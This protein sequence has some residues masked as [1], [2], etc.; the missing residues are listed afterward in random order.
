MDGA[1]CDS[2]TL[3]NVRRE[4]GEIVKVVCYEGLMVGDLKKS[5]GGESAPLPRESRRPLL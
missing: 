3:Q 4:K 2:T 1:E 5:E